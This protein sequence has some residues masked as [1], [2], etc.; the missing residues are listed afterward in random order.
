VTLARTS[1][2]VICVIAAGPG[3]RDAQRLVRLLTGIR[4]HEPE[5]KS[6][7]VVSDNSDVV[8]AQ[9]AKLIAPIPLLY[10]LNPA[11]GMGS[12]TLDRLTVG[13]TTAYAAAARDFPGSHVVK[14]DI[15]AAV[16][17]PF[18]NQ[19]SRFFDQH[20]RAGMIGTFDL[21]CADQKRRPDFAAWKKYFTRLDRP[22]WI[23]PKK[24]KLF[25]RYFGTGKA[26]SRW[27]RQCIAA[28]GVPGEF[29][30]GGAYALRCDTLAAWRDIGLLSEHAHWLGTLCSEDVGFSMWCQ[31]AGF[32][33]ERFNAPDQTFGVH[34]PGL[35][36]PPA[37]LLLRGHA[38]VHSI[39]CDT[40]ANEAALV[41]FFE[42][43]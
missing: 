6:V 18:A 24:L 43:L 28:G 23:W 17:K 10:L 35:A 31:I 5:L 1:T 26:I 14:L 38:I 3:T 22:I 40:D 37:Q 4:R 42:Q 7:I 33:L 29:V 30:Q 13:L 15:D 12:G 41:R 16:V 9:V 20:E 19:V 11:A 34:N 25:S 36:M 8:Q 2:S 27:K 39:K 21:D 32:T